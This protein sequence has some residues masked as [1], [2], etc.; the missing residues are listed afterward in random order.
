MKSVMKLALIVLTA[1]GLSLPLA[2]AAQGTPGQVLFTNIHVFD[3]VS[4]NRI[5]NANVLVEGN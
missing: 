2:V 4:K 1:L 3:G 5:E